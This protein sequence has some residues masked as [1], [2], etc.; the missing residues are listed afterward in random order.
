MPWHFGS[1]AADDP[2]EELSQIF[3]DFLKDEPRDA[4]AK[5][6]APHT[7]D[8]MEVTLDKL[9]EFMEGAEL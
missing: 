9:Q 1:V 8:D 2:D 4:E 5:P 6:C 7:P 3:N